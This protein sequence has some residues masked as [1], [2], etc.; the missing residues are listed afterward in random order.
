M[1]RR[2]RFVSFAL[3]VWGAGVLAASTGPAYAGTEPTWEAGMYFS[4]L[5]GEYGQDHRSELYYGSL[6]VKRY[7]GW[8]DLTVTV[9][10]LSI[11][12]DGVTI[13]DGSVEPIT[14]GS[15]GSGL[16]D[17][18]V[19]ARYY[20]LQQDGLLPFLDL[21]GSLK[22]PTADA[23]EG[24]GTGEPDFTV[25]GEF[26]WRL[27][28]SDWFVLGDLGYTFVGRPDDFDLKNR[29]LY[30]LGL[31]Y[32][33]NPKVTLSGY[34]DGRT[35]IVEGNEDALS[36]LLMGEYKFRPDLRM[37]TIVELGL[38]DGAPDF[39]LTLGLRKRL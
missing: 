33:V 4:Y 23:D 26:T 37:D 7:L 25:L 24:L 20:A 22:I 19:A 13:V 28:D 21:V 11:P 17:I 38:T 5:T 6:M 39:G 3:L 32:E 16:G 8:G 1:P 14:T 2:P 9:P 15:G 12:S 18:I 31:A 34:L 27:A 10:Y 29:W 36:V 35:A 30:S